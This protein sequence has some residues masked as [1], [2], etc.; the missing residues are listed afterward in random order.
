MDE[1]HSR[2]TH[3]RR[4][5]AVLLCRELSGLS[6]SSHVVVSCDVVAPIKWFTSGELLKSQYIVTRNG[7]FSCFTWRVYFHWKPLDL[8]V[9]HEWIW[10]EHHIVKYLSFYKLLTD[11]FP[12]LISKIYVVHFHFHWH[13]HWIR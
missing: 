8:I 9:I 6:I 13:M 2:S 12:Y 4:R 11:A 5:T 7:F 3:F 1:Y 10:R